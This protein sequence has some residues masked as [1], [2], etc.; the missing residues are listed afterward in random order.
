MIEVLPEGTRYELPGQASKRARVVDTLKTLYSSW[1]Y[2]QVDVPVLERYHPHH[3]RLAQSFKLS[4]RDSGV[5]TLRSD[6][7]PMLANLVRTNYPRVV[8][9]EDPALRFQYAGKVWHA[10][11]PD[12]ARTREFTQV[13]LELI[14]VSNA[15]ADAELIHLA[16]ESVR[17]VDLVPRVEI[18]NPGFVR[19]LFQL[20]AVPKT[21]QEG[22]ADA[23]DRKDQSTL[24]SLLGG[25]DLAPDLFSAFQATLDLYGDVGVLDAARRVA[26]WEET[27]RE[28][29]RLEGVLSEFEDNSDLLLDLGMAR[30]LS[31]YT[32]VTFRAYTF[33]FGQPLL[34]GGR[35]D[36]ALLPFAAGFAI[37]LERLMSA[38]PEAGEPETPLVMSLDDVSARTLRAA[39]FSVMRALT[40]DVEEARRQAEAYGIAYLLAEQ[41]EPLVSD[42]PQQEV[43]ERLLEGDRG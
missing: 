10:I 42:P 29:D 21:L 30:R 8:T 35:Y 16:R 32:G 2:L 11:N 33:D 28:L 31:Y 40:T 20:A 37:G 3:P 24:V 43:L 17:A 18:G 34:G 7:T 13:G 4:D 25:L 22:L 41:L 12:M 1:G 6:F 38:L 39:G 15:R 27:C 5:L 26:P 36:G 23:I 9:G 14:G 19:A